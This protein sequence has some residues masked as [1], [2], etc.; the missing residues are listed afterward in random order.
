MA[1]RTVHY[2]MAFAHYLRERRV[3]CIS[4]DETRRTF[5]NQQSI[6]SLD[7]VVTP[8]PGCWLLV[9]VKGRKLPAG[10]LSLENWATEDDIASMNRWQQV[11]GE[12]S[13]A[14]LAFVYELGDPVQR[15]W[16]AE[17]FCHNGQHFGCLCVK[18]AE[19][20][21]QVKVRSPKWKTVSIPRG[22]FTRMAMPFDYYLNAGKPR[23]ISASS[24]ESETQSSDFIPNGAGRNN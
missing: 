20:Q 14:I 23:T 19:Y 9:D 11:F 8:S 21:S 4:I 6:K 22:A 12:N 5:T 2:E 1:D 16:F 10:S 13:T 15:F 17:S 3:A 24:I 7:F 18:L